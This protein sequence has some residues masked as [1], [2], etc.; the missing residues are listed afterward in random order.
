ML[1]S[2]CSSLQERDLARAAI[3]ELLFNWLRDQK[4]EHTHTRCRI[5]TIP[6]LSTVICTSTHSI[7]KH[8]QWL[9]CNH[10]LIFSCMCVCVRL[11]LCLPC[12]SSMCLCESQCSVLSIIVF[13]SR[14]TPPISHHQQWS[15][16]SQATKKYPPNTDPGSAF[17]TRPYI[18]NH[19]KLLTQ[20]GPRQ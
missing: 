18:I 5:N 19:S 14:I 17:P 20:T 15:N 12:A 2:P 9:Q 4:H 7:T 8:T 11:W 13:S 3:S 1:F 6:Y 10:Y 16:G